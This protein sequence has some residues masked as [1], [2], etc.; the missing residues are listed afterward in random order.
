MTAAA[1]NREG[2]VDMLGTIVYWDSFPKAED[3]GHVQSALK[4]LGLP[5]EAA[6]SKRDRDA[7]IRAV[8]KAEKEKLVR[9]LAEKPD[10]IVFQFTAEFLAANRLDYSYEAQ[11]RFDKQSG[12]ITSDSNAVLGKVQ[13]LFR[14]AAANY[15][16]RDLTAIV[17]RLFKKS[18]D[19]LPLRAKGAVYFVPAVYMAEVER[20][21]QFAERFGNRLQT[22]AVPKGDTPS[23]RT[24]LEAFIA[25]A[26][27]EVKVLGEEITA[28]VTALSSGHENDIS[29]KMKNGRLRKAAKILARVEVYEATLGEKLESVRAGVK[30]AKE[31]LE[32]ALVG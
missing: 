11:V 25:D 7:F 9:R 1:M 3:V 24:V 17:Q 12:N 31:K 30:L 20:I 16:K 6:R 5:V 14:Y 21:G 18:A 28:L 29:T 32:T 2:K 10:A 4:E 27:S 19:L 22:I 23:R 26:D 8:R 15:E 13:E